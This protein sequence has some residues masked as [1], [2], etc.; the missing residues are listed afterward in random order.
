MVGDLIFQVS[1][2]ILIALP[3]VPQCLLFFLIEKPIL[4][5]E[6]EVCAKANV[7]IVDVNEVQILEPDKVGRSGDD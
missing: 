1:K 3:Q 2:P 4:L 7:Q 6:I 5:A